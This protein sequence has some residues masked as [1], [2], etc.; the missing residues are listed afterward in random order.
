VVLLATSWLGFFAYREVQYSGDLWW[1]FALRGDAPRFLRSAVGAAAV[2]LAFAVARLLRPARAREARGEPTGIPEAVPDIVASSGRTTA[3]LAFL[4]DKRFLLSE[5]ETAFIM[6]GVEGRSWVSM[7]DPQ[8]DPDAYPELV[9]RFRERALRHGGWPVFYQVRPEFLPLY[10]DT[11]LTLLK[12]GE[13]ALVP[14]QD[15]TLEGSARKTFRYVLRRVEREGATF[16]VLS[17]EATREALSRLRAVSDAWLQQ[18]NTQEKGFSLG[19]FSEAY[20]SH[21]PTAVIRREGE[22]VAFANVWPGGEG[23]EYSVDL[24]RYHPEDAPTDAMEYLFLKMI[25]WGQEEGYTRFNL[26]MAPLSGLEGGPLAPLWTRLGGTVFRYGEHFYN[27]QGLRAYKQ[28]FD[29]VWEPRYL[30]SSGRLAVPLVLGNVASLVSG[31]LRGALT[32]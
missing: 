2:L 5:A 22:I 1:R 24:M 20:L 10:V 16:D 28:K 9:W 19:A 4:G 25:L 13:E 14:V 11:G 30:A 29:P 8:G 7:G 15:F 18:K 31:G 27:F 23:G 6:F 26:G 3:N 21:F 17:P 32:R 12:L